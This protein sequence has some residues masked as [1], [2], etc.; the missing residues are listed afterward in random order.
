MFGMALLAAADR[1]FHVRTTVA[2]ALAAGDWVLSDRWVYSTY[3]FFGARGIDHATLASLN[4]GVPSPDLVVLLD[5]DPAVARERVRA[6]DGTVVKFE[7][8]SLAFMED[9]RRRFLD[10][11]DDDALVLDATAGPDQ[12]ASA[13]A[14]RALA[15]LA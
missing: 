3:A 8:T 5:I 13:I 4:V 7:E 15:L 9:V 2:P 1:Q 12:L 6:R 11:V 10:L 14:S